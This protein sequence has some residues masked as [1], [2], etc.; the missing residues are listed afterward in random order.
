MKTS[1]S[2]FT[3]DFG[4][5][6]HNEG[7]TLPEAETI[8]H[9]GMTV[10]VLETAGM[11]IGFP[12]MIYLLFKP[13]DPFL[14]K[15]S[16]PWLLLVPALL[17]S[18]H[19]LRYGLSSAALLISGQ[20]LHLWA[21]DAYNV[22]QLISF[23]A[24]YLILGG[25]TGEFRDLW[26][27]KVQRC[28]VDKAEMQ[29][30]LDLITRAFTLLK[31][32]HARLEDR[33]TATE[34]SLL[35]SVEDARRRISQIDVGDLRAFGEIVLDVFANQAMV[36]AASV[37]LTS[38]TYALPAKPSAVLGE[39]RSGVARHPLVLRAIKAGKLVAVDSQSAMS[40]DRSY[41]VA[42][43]P[44]VSASNRF[45]G[46]IAIH[47]MPFIAFHNE[48]FAV[49]S[50]LAANFADMLEQSTTKKVRMFG[51]GDTEE[52]S[53]VARIGGQPMRVTKRQ[54]AWAS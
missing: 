15:T 6:Q 23:G 16:I 4:N 32:S 5:A 35:A 44:L 42:A 22:G 36:Q 17:G 52:S 49:L 13:L 54:R 21:H 33:F 48:Q 12:L 38:R 46:V 37:F 3:D 26:S 14:M 11:S 8:R 1:R 18:M 24:A 29:I 53:S 10:A 40:H 20:I 19:G 28:L 27:R 45:Y 34:W 50:Q 25:L 9:K 39:P 43:V 41:V 47:E 2:H 7:L 31:L 51:L 30:K